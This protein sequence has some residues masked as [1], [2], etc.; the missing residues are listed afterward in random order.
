MASCTGERPLIQIDIEKVGLVE[1]VTK[2]LKK[3]FLPKFK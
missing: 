1:H 2:Q 3:E